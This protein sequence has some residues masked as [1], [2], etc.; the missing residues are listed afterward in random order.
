MI[1]IY[2]G[3]SAAGKDYLFKFAIK[4]LGLRPIVSATTRPM[5]DGEVEGVD[6]F[7]CTKEEFLEKVNKGEIFEYRSY[8]T[9]VNNIPDVWYY[10][11][12]E[13]NPSDNYAVVLD[14][15]GTLN[16]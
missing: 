12:P 9:K 1:T 3:K 10:G 7:F 11:S 8:N 16:M 5:R 2:C 6:Y 13:V 15:N 14:L 4:E